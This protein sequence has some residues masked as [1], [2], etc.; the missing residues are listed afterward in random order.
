[1][2]EIECATTGQR[3]GYPPEWGRAAGAAYSDERTAWI[4]EHIER[5][6]PTTRTSTRSTSG[7]SAVAA[8]AARRTGPLSPAQ[9]RL[10]LAER[11]RRSAEQAE[12]Q[13]ELD[14]HGACP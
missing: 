12:R 9:A 6:G 10:A 3:S 5:R 2:N 7:A 13:I 1:M 8:L 11:K 14:A 4:R